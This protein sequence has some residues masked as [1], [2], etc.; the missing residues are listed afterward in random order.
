MDLAKF[1][2]QARVRTET[3]KMKQ[4]TSNL[5]IPAQSPTY[6]CIYHGAQGHISSS[7]FNDKKWSTP[8]STINA[9]MFYIWMWVHLS[10]SCLL[11]ALV[12]FCCASWTD[13]SVFILLLLL[14]SSLE[15]EAS[16]IW[17][18]YHDLWVHSWRY[19]CT[20]THWHQLTCSHS[21]MQWHTHTDI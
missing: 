15:I 12:T 21:H 17:T 6:P 7:I 2:D 10:C 13:C 1:S 20:H 19:T 8:C 18:I 9:F 5:A 16:S 14:T 3:E 4:N 11:P